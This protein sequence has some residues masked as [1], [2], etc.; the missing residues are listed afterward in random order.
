[1]PDIR[2]SRPHIAYIS[3]HLAIAFQYAPAAALKRKWLRRDEQ[4]RHSLTINAL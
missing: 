4:S 2:T 1:M 3:G